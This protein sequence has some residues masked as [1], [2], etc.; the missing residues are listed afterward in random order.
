METTKTQKTITNRK[1]N[2]E[3]VITSMGTKCLRMISEKEYNHIAKY[4]KA[5]IN[6]NQLEE[7]TSEEITFLE[8]VKKSDVSCSLASVLNKISSPEIILNKDELHGKFI[9]NNVIELIDE[10]NLKTK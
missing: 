7:L 5:L 10:I 2:D 6:G 3:P 9:L 8:F 1:T 4:R